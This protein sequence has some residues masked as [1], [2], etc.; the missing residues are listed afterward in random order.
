MGGES[1]DLTTTLLGQTRSTAAATFG[2]VTLLTLIAFV[3]PSTH[4]LIGVAISSQ[5]LGMLLLFILG[6]GLAASNAYLND[7]VVL[8]LAAVFVPLFVLE[9]QF[10][11]GRTAGVMLLTSAGAIPALLTLFTALPGYLFGRA[12]CADTTS[13]TRRLQVVLLGDSPGTAL[14]VLGAVT[15]L[16]LSGVLLVTFVVAP[17]SESALL[18]S[19]ADVGIGLRLLAIGLSAAVTYHYG[20]LFVAWGV[21]AIPLVTF[22]T[23][24]FYLDPSGQAGLEAV[25]M[26]SF[27]GLVLALVAGTAGYL[28]GRTAALLTSRSELNAGELI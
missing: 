21:T 13:T 11:V 6:V 5:R 23:L 4:P 22:S 12:L 3:W 8:S 15:L 20:G 17:G 28:I 25:I 14:R 7:G 24:E 1:G 9:L 10:L 16:S 2:G 26:G 19:T 18:S 27:A